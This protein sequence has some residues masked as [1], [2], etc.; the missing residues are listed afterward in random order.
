V[1]DVQ[2]RHGELLGE[3]E[4]LATMKEDWQTVEHLLTHITDL[5]FNQ[6]GTNTQFDDMTFWAFRREE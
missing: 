1:T 3:D 6:M 4:I 2:D 5:V